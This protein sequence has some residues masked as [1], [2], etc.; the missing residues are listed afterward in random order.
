MTQPGLKYEG[1]FV[2]DKYEGYGKLVIKDKINYLGQFKAGQFH[3]DGKLEFANGKQYNGNFSYGKKD[4]QGVL[5]IPVK[6][7]MSLSD[8]PVY[9]T[10]TGGFKDDLYHGFGKYMYADGST[11]EGNWQQGKKQGKGSF[12]N[13]QPEVGQPSRFEGL[14]E[15]DEMVGEDW[16][17]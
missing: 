9:E 5:K 17:Q 7:V 2:N 6:D 11:Y 4:G 1:K 3:G 8:K 14:F 16:N 10:Y 12:I 13:T 15:N